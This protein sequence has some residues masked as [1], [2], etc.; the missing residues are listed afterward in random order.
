[1]IYTPHV[2][3]TDVDYIDF[4]CVMELKCV[5]QTIIVLIRTKIFFSEIAL[6]RG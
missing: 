4:S 1:M 2:L 5:T 6:G 3:V